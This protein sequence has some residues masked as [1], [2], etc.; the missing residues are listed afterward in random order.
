[1]RMTDL[2]SGLNIAWF[3]SIGLVIFALV[4]TLVLLRTAM[5]TRGQ[6]RRAGSLPLDDAPTAEG[7]AR[8][9]DDHA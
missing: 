2:V 4:F 3:P 5:M 9:E 1:M 8:K 6:S 7:A